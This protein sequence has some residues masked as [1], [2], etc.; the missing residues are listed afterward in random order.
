VKD[1]WPAALVFSIIIII[2]LFLIPETENL[3]NANPIVT[4]THIKPE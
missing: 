2:T 4:P 3:K 1:S